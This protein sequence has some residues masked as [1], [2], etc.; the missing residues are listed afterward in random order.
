M[1]KKKIILLTGAAGS[2]LSSCEYIF[3]EL[4]YF[5]VKNVLTNVVDD[6][7]T[8]FINDNE[9]QKLCLIMHAVSVEEV[10]PLIK[11]RDDADYQ[12]I[13][14][15]CEEKELEKRYTLTRKIHPRSIIERCSGEEA[16]KKDIAAINRVIEFAD[17][18]ID[19]TSI[20]I[21]QLRNTLYRHLEGY[22][23]NQNLS[24]T[25]MSFGLKNGIP[26]GL[27]MF[28][29]VRDI[30][31]PYWIEELK[32]LNGE[33][34]PVKKYLESFPITKEIINNI[35][36]YL[37]KS[38]EEVAKSGRPSYTIGIACSG[39]QHRSTYVANYLKEKYQDKYRTYVIHR[40]SPKLN[41]D[42]N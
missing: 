21:K 35:M 12:I 37:D 26:Q 4:G 24:L 34:E 30:P 1:E 15:T 22:E 9:A 25:F 29:D 40:D 42:E 20:S 16:I 31:N 6:L 33:D 2:G 3:E 17:L 13:V 7:L 19:T 28:F 27:D 14:L 39:G 38:L 32:D 23:D 10:I 8:S 36:S 41:K 11:R 18:T 5:V